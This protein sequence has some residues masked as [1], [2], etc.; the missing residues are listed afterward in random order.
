[1]HLKEKSGGDKD[2]FSVEK[3][4]KR[5]QKKQE[6]RNIKAY[7]KGKQEV[8]VFNFINHTISKPKQENPGT[9]KCKHRQ[10]IKKE[11]SRNL[12]IA[13]LQIEEDIKK[14]ERDMYKI[15][16]SL[17]RHSDANS[18]V[19]KSLKQ[20][21]TIKLNEIQRL[22]DKAGNISSEQNVRTFK[23]KLTVF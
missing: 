12:N 14:I 10:E 23:K 7:E 2:L 18:Q 9:S 8:D 5:L 20:K 6:Q 1:M 3:K 22:K 15:R 21:L 13:S 16:E 17:T 11:T 19:H 4:L